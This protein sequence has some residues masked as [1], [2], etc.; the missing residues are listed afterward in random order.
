MKSSKLEN[1]I[2]AKIIPLKSVGVRNRPQRDQFSKIQS[3]LKVTL[4][5]T[6]IRSGKKFAVINLYLSFVIRLL[7]TQWLYFFN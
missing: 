5:I 4:Q 3:Y 6:E 1:D 7:K 2:F